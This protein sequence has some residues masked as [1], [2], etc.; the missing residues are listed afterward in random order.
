MLTII[1]IETEEDSALW[2]ISDGVCKEHSFF[3][4]STPSFQNSGPCDLTDIVVRVN[5][6]KKNILSERKQNSLRLLW[7]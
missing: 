6:F 7:R 1:A 4:S 3:L 5:H 2:A